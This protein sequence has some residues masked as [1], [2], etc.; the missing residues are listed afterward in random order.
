MP[1]TANLVLERIFYPAIRNIFILMYCLANFLIKMSDPYK[2]FNK[3]LDFL[4][5]ER[6]EPSFEL[7]HKIIKAHL[8][9]IPFENISKLLYKKK[10]MNDIPDL[11]A[12]LNGIGQ[13]NFGGTCYA[14]NYYLY[15][16]L[17]HLGFD[18]KLCG[19]D[20][21]NPDVHLIS[22]I[23]IENMEYIADAGYAAPFLEP[24]PRDLKEDFTICSGREKYIVKPQDGNGNTKVEQYYDNELRHWYTA[25]PQPRKIDEFRKVIADSY[26]DNAA[27]MN[28][29]RIVRFYE[30]GF[31]SLRNF[32]L[33]E[34]NGPDYSSIEISRNDLPG[35]INEKFG[36]PAI[37]ADEVLSMPKEFRNIYD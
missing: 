33:T 7:L 23:K 16:L 6:S 27:F 10:G 36:I 34:L 32:T 20:M 19:A 15:L 25:K 17:T 2:L 8:K 22:M 29:L 18:V 14:N 4:G 28:A 11:P 3:Y 31:R 12:Y 5:I 13:Y 24:L 35:V 1:N 9:K 37:I 21:R 26:A 30:N